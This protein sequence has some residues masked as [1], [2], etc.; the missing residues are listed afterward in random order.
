MTGTFCNAAMSRLETFRPP[1]VKS[2]TD[3]KGQVVPKEEPPRPTTAAHATL[4]YAQAA[5]AGFVIA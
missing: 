1:A 4:V 2:T 3:H 5:S